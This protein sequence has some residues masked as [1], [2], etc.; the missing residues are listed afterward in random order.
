MRLPRR[1]AIALASA[2]LHAPLLAFAA[3]GGGHLPSSGYPVV[4]LNDGTAMPALGFGTCCRASAKGKP[5]IASTKEYLTQ[6]GRLIDTAQMYENE[7]ALAEAIRESAVP[8]SELWLTDKVN[9]GPW[10]GD[11]PVTTR[12][13]AFASVE[14]SLKELD[15]SYL[16]LMHVHGTW[17]ISPSQQVEVWRGLIDAKAKGLVRRIGVSNFER[18][19]IEALAAATGVLPCVHQI[20]YHPW[21]PP[22][23]FELVRWC[24]KQQIAITAYG[25]L[26][27]S[28]HKAGE[29]EP[30]ESTNVQSIATT[31]GCS[32]AAV[33]LRWA[34][35]QDVAVIPGATSA[36]HIRDNL[37]VPMFE[38]TA[39][40]RRLLARARPSTFKR[41][42][43][44]LEER[45]CAPSASGATCV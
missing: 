40:D 9:T 34:L 27:G 6:G 26:G 31:H 3:A 24:Q 11:G 36:E 33:L 35:N 1:S 43:N 12:A 39:S 5:L 32:N 8:R 21:V 23:T 7:G 28:R 20:E 18:A 19:E 29:S 41:W 45:T 30:S 22:A 14:A 16:D 15:T 42:R 17:A 10:V 38:L 37:N 25:S 13:G 44:L 2:P 4:K